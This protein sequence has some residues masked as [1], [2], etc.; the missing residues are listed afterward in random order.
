MLYQFKLGG[1]ANNLI[2]VPTQTS[3]MWMFQHNDQADKECM[4]SCRDRQETIDT[5]KPSGSNGQG[6]GA[7][8]ANLIII[9]QHKLG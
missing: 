3:S 4:E 1:L 9:Y 2:I 8:N 7:A 5:N 6:K